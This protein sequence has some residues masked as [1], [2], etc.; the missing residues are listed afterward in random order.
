MN[1]PHLPL[2]RALDRPSVMIGFPSRPAGPTC[3]DLDFRAA[4]EVCVE[5][6]ARLGHQV[7]A[8]VSPPPEVYVRET[9]V[10]QRGAGVHG[11][12]RP[13]RPVVLGAPPRGRARRRPPGRRAAAAGAARAHRGR[14]AQRARPEAADRRLEQ[15]GLGVP[16]DLSITAIC[17]D[18]LA[19]SAR[20]PLTSVALPSAEVSAGGRGPADAKA[21]RRTGTRGHTP[22]PHLTERAS[23]APRP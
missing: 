8:L 12:R 7:V 23:T 3:I 18:E 13:A 5:Q 6:L 1:D 19:E 14:R 4:G 16:G 20:I 17:P 22:R 10:A 11:S 9:G 2:L 21:V 15:L